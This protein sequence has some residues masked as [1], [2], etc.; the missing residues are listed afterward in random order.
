MVPQGLRAF[1]SLGDISVRG[2]IVTVE[3]I[4]LPLA[5]RRK[6]RATIKTPMI[7]IAR[8]TFPEIYLNHFKCLPSVRSPEH[9]H[10][11]VTL[12]SLS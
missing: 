4:I 10:S 11:M 2:C 5:G 3:V 1:V 7:R 8:T 12:V 6:A 9:K